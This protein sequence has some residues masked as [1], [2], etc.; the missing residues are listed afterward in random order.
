[1]EE[2]ARLL[3]YLPL[4]YK[5]RGEQ[6]YVAFLWDAFQTNYEHEKY[7]FAFLA[8]HMLT[9]SFVYFNIWQVKQARPGDFEKGLIGL[10]V[11]ENA[12]LKATS[13]FVFSIVPESTMLRFLKLVACDSSRIGAFAK[14]VRDRNDTAHANGNVFYSTQAAL[15]S[16]IGEVLRFVAEI[17]EHSAPVV[18]Q[19]Y[20]NFLFDNWDREAREYPDD[21]DQIR[22]VLLHNDYFSLE[23]L[24]LCR[25][26]DVDSLPDS[27]SRTE[28]ESLHRACMAML[29]DIDL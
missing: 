5:N 17:Q 1:M 21:K 20:G 23:D 26:L 8:Y 12:L 9:M 4:S 19:I 3:D 22:E 14:L 6:D 13:P 28:Q 25:G 18:L 27:N 11:H 16:K 24:R 2:A 7:Q 10:A 29:D 15:D